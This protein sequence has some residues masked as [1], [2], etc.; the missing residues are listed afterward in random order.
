[1][2]S[3]GG[4]ARRACDGAHLGG[5]PAEA[6]SRAVVGGEDPRHAE[7]LELGDLLRDDDPAAA[8][9]DPDRGAA[10]PGELLDEVGEELHVPAL[11]RA[12]GDAVD[13]LVDRGVGDLGDRAVVAEVHDLAPLL[14]EQAADQVDRRVVAVEERRRGDEPQRPAGSVIHRLEV[15]PRPARGVPARRAVPWE[16]T[17]AAGGSLR[18]SWSSETPVRQ[19]VRVS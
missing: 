5:H 6:E 17:R 18:P 2:R 1:M 8:A 16:R 10:A 14:L 4:A 13:V 19:G 12:D 3:I 7:G 9:E 15:T 11:V